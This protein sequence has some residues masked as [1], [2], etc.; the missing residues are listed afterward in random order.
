MKSH[1]ELHVRKCFLTGVLTVLPLLITLLVFQFLFRVIR[2]LFSPLLMRFFPDTPIWL[3]YWVTFSAVLIL[4]YF[5]GLLTS[6]FLGRWFW[7]RFE[8]VLMKIPL[9]RSVYSASREVV[10]IF[11]QPEKKGFREVVLVEFPR[12]GMKAVGFITG[13][14]TDEFGKLYYKVFIPTTP[15]PT[16]GFL[17]IVETGAAVRCNLSVEE[18]IKIIMSGGI[19]GPQTMNLHTVMDAGDFSAQDSNRNATAERTFQ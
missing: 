15:N 12:A 6:H 10:L 13:T 5:L 11:A 2:N 3:K 7:T 14:V 18:G 9:L 17:E 19:L 16:T 1:F 8:S 4:L